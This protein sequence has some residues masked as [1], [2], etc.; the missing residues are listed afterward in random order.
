MY[1]IVQIL[2]FIH[3]FNTDVYFMTSALLSVQKHFIFTNITL[4]TKKDIEKCVQSTYYIIHIT[5]Y[6]LYTLHTCYSE[7]PEEL[8][9]ISLQNYT[10]CTQ[11]Y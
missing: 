8:W 6:T 5:H 9:Q 1:S 3:F 10:N 7:S 11:N 4:P 2:A